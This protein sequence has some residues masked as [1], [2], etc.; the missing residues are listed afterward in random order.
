MEQRYVE[1]GFK[2]DGNTLHVQAPARAAD[3][4]PGYYMVFVI[5]AKGVP[6]VAKILLMGVAPDPNPQVVPVLA[7]PGNQTHAVGANVDLPLVASDPNGDTLNFVAAGLPPGLT[8]SAATGRL[9]GSPTTAGSYNVVLSASDGYNTASVNL[10][11]TVTG[12]APLQFDVLPLPQ[13]TLTGATASFSAHAN[14]SGVTYKWNFGDGTAETAWAASGGA[15]HTYGRAGSFYV[16]VSARDDQGMVVTQSFWQLVYLPSTA[17]SPTAST[18]LLSET[19]ASGVPRLWVVNQDGNSVSVFHQTTRA[20]L[21]VVPVGAAPRTL[22]RAANG[23][24]WVSN[25]RDATLSVIDPVSLAVVRTIALPRASQ[26]FGLVMNPAGT[27][28]FVALE[29][30]GQLLR[31]DT[32]SYAQTGALAIG[33][34]A[35]H[36]AVSGDG[37]QV[38]VSRF[39]TPALPG[40][41]TATVTPTAATGGQVLVVSASAMT[42]QRT[43]VLQHSDKP[44]F[45]NQGRGIPNYLG[46]VAISPDGTQAWVP[47]KQ[48]NVLRGTRRD[49]NALNFQ[50]TVRAISSRINLATGQEDLASRVDHDNASMASAAV[51]DPRGVYLFVALETSRDGGG[52]GR[53]CPRAT[54]A[55][56]R[57]PRAARPGAVA[58]RPHALRQQ[59]HGP[60]RGRVRP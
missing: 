53:P 39:V 45:E 7:S 10:L 59:L 60:Q 30:G 51:F 19:S 13:A 16:T 4:P 11:W 36:V 40:E 35:R 29:A 27:Q 25:K 44:D 54:D 18:N 37:T 38:H 9:T 17:G 33:L 1:L 2:V 57:G 50:N 32:A 6:S 14:G 48:D 3:A 56:R 42:L 15:S 58:R 20:R 22:A 49:G 23:Q 24:V 43:T 46:A 52:G 26:P 5:D 47:S 21:A 12:A 8:L 31:F 55:L 34:N 28:A 41:A